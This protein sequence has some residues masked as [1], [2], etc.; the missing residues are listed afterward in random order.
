M[1][2]ARRLVRR[3]SAGDERREFLD[4]AAQ[5]RRPRSPRRDPRRRAALADRAAQVPVEPPPP[6]RAAARLP[7]GLARHRRRVLQLQPDLR[8]RHDDRRARRRG[9]SIAPRR[10]PW[11]D[12]TATGSRAGSIAGSRSRSTTPWLLTTTEDL[13]SPA[14]TGRRP[15]WVPL[16]HW[17]TARVQRLTWRDAFVGAPLP[18]GDAPHQ[19]PR[20]LFHPYIVYRALGCAAGVRRRRLDVWLT[21]EQLAKTAPAEQRRARSPIPTRVVSNGEY[22]PWPQTAAQR[23]VEHELGALADALRSARSAWT[24]GGSCARAAAWRRPSSR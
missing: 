10:A 5:P 22:L 3:P 7:D 23:R 11:P 12:G 15:A 19:A 4:F 21:D 16:L 8:A 14:A 2:D 24:A 17:Y 9:R 6:L 20:A 1:V 13:R 18:R